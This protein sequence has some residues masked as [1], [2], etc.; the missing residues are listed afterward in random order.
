MFQ[1]NLQPPDRN[2]RSPI[3]RRDFIRLLGMGV[4]SAGLAGVD[5][6]QV[7]AQG[8]TTSLADWNAST[9]A[10]QLGKTFTVSLGSAGHVALNLSQVK[11]GISKIYYGP[12]KVTNAPAG[13]S[14]VL[15]FRGPAQPALNPK[16]YAFQQSQLG[17]FSLFVMPG[18]ADA[19]GRNY[20]AVVNH[21]H[22]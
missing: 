11:D 9:F 5:A 10:A 12:Q 16:T 14:F 2:S 7:L 1:D 21:V 4:A 8:G 13:S 3:S 19:T 20:I 18:S 15:V 17:A 6:R 22:A